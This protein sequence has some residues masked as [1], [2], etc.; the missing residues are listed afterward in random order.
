[1]KIGPLSTLRRAV[2]PIFLFLVLSLVLTGC[3]EILIEDQVVEIDAT[4]VVRG[5]VYLDRNGKQ[6][7]DGLDPVVPNLLVRAVQALGGGEVGSAVSDENGLFVMD[8]VPVGTFRL[9]VDPASLPDSLSV[10]GLEGETFVVAA[11]S[12]TTVNFNA[13]F[14]SY[15]LGEVATLEQGIRVFTTGIALNS[16]DAEGDATVHLTDG[17]DFLRAVDVDD[18]RVTTGDSIRVR[19]R[20]ALEEGLPVLDDVEPFIIREDVAVPLPLDVSTD[21]A[22]VADGAALNAALVRIQAAEI[23]DT[24]TVEGDLQATVDD[25]SGPVDLMLRDY[26][27][28][29][30]GRFSPGFARV[31]EASGL[32][33]GQLQ[34]GGGLLWR[35]FPRSSADVAVDE[36]PARSLSQIRQLAT[37]QSGQG[38]TGHGI[39][40][41]TEDGPIPGTIHIREQGV[42]LR[43]RQ[44]SETGTTVLPG[45]SIRVRGLTNRESL[46]FPVLDALE[47]I[48]LKPGALAS[49]QPALRSTARAA[50][51]DN[52]Q[53]PDGF[54]RVENATVTETATED[55]VFVATV[56]D[57]SGP[58]EVAIHGTVG[59]DTTALTV[60][61]TLDSV[62][63]LLVPLRDPLDGTVSWRILPR[64]PG[65]IQVAP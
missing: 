5:T 55:G 48:N 13:S 49:P 54:I 36:F 26:L 57:S 2:V 11:D 20:T 27:G 35:I 8:E 7:R 50:T 59:F 3:G 46:I 47:I 58:V 9:S 25:G 4:G 33:V 17:T 53:L 22:A 15:E 14:P 29:D 24:V 19:G 60:G 32:L 42:H 18:V 34:P 45:D 39:V 44:A 63:G 31:E 10:F 1:M 61:S 43:V 28:F 56:D 38:V 30:R 12:V 65:D 6:I 16:R 40:L 21:V 51:A 41:N 52:G 37:D 62:V 23:L 64:V